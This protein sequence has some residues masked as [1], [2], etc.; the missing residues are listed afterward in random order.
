MKNSFI[1]SVNTTDRPGRASAI[2]PFE[3]TSLTRALLVLRTSARH[4]SQVWR[5]LRSRLLREWR[6]PGTSLGRWIRGLRRTRQELSKNRHLKMSSDVPVPDAELRYFWDLAVCP[7]T[8]DI[9][10]NLCH[11]EVVRRSRNLASLHV[12]I[13]PEWEKGIE[14]TSQ[15]RAYDRIIDSNKREVASPQCHHSMPAPDAWRTEDNGLPESRRCRVS[16][17]GPFTIRVPTRLLGSKPDSSRTAFT[18][19]GDSVLRVLP[20]RQDSGRGSRL[21]AAIYLLDRLEG[22]AQ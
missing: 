22:G 4:P 6:S 8:F 7:L 16:L 12:L 5:W 19:A 21:H 2:F 13:V 15:Y 9:V 11:A 3:D 14:Y 10:W 20:Y 18:P 17:E 1:G